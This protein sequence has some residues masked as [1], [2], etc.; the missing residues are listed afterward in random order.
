L[1]C[2]IFDLPDVGRFDCAIGNP[3]F[4]TARRERTAP[5]YR[6]SHFEYH[7]IDLASDLADEGV[8]LIP[9]ES[10]PFRYS[11]EQFYSLL[12]P[13]RIPHYGRFRAATE[14]ELG[15]NCGID[16][17]FYRNDWK[18][19][20]PRTEVVVCDF[21]EAR[22]RRGQKVSGELFPAGFAPDVCAAACPTTAEQF[23][24]RIWRAKS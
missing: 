17:S 21:Q 10:S 18:G 22:A 9:Q 5:R 16:T 7:A 12:D 23:R 8:F 20:S 3:P 13:Q 14:I 19:V 11:G 15:P 24:P 6:G 2:D 4:G 1:C